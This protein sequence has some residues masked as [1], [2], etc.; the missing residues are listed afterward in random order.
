MINFK[1]A[2]F[3][4]CFCISITLC[5]DAQS[6][7]VLSYNY[8]G[9]PNYG[10]KIKT[11]LPF[12]NGSQMPTLHIEGYNYGTAKP[13]GLT[14]VWY[15]FGGN[16]Y[17]PGI[18]SCGSYTPDVYLSNENG[19][20][21]IFIND[22][23][24]FQRFKV[25]GFAQGMSETATWFQG[26]TAV[27]E[28]LGGTNQTLVPYSNSFKGNISMPNGVWNANGSV[29]IASTTLNTYALLQVGNP[30]SAGTS[31]SAIFQN[32][33][34]VAPSGSSKHTY[35]YSDNN[36]FYG[37]NAYDYQSNTYLPLT[38]G[39]GANNV[40]I[41]GDGGNV[42]IGTRNPGPYRLAVEGT[43]G[44]R[45]LKV[46][47]VTPWADYVF[48]PS[49]KLKPLSQIEAFIKENRHLP[50][51]PSAEEVEKN[52]VDVG[53]TV[54]LL[55]KK[56]EELTLYIIDVKKENESL[57]A[58]FESMKNQLNGTKLQSKKYK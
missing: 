10:V 43:V 40:Y 23:S 44:V 51:I 45:K 41:A 2:F 29:G 31:Q 17:A 20:V 50:E 47:Q 9:T 54:S 8:N 25:S 37:I 34:G 21:S 57:K 4:F 36:G 28:A 18:S 14:L 6:Y 52:G 46:T 13:I 22:R 16:F 19:L 38:I 39:W 48:D 56:I 15:I 55:L 32:G 1:G 24:Y 26:W 3:L 5:A 30:G 7:D 58:G 11:N 42:G 27:D 35:L 49:Y 53:E 33:I 12:L